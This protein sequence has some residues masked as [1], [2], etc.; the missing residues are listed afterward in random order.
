MAAAC[1]GVSIGI[2]Y[3]GTGDIA[4]WFELRNQH[5]EYPW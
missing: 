3:M 2:T 4:L 1:H 5:C